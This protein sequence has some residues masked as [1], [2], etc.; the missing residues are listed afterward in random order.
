MLSKISPLLLTGTVAAMLLLESL[1]PLVVLLPGRAR[2]RH[3]ARNVAL[4]LVAAL[5][6]FSGNV[7]FIGASAWASTHHVGLLNQFDTPWALRFLVALLSI[8][9]FEYWRH[10]AHHR[11]PFLWRLH[12]VHHSDP[13]VDATTS[14]RGHPFES[15]IAYT[16]FTAIVLL[17]GLDPLSL[18]LR[19]IVAATALA[20]HHAGIRLPARADAVISLVTPTPRTH[21]VHHHRDVVFTDTNFGTLFTWWDRLFGTFTPGS[22]VQVDARTG[23]DGFDS[24]RAQSV[25]GV[26]LSPFRR[27]PPV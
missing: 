13:H 24:E 17:L 10:R 23:L 12:R 19:T 3:G 15:L 21:R 25:L 1:A 5:F 11:L 9:F 18:A 16:Y 6:A 8:D 7:V 27:A 22:R 20:W 4:A 26:L 14:V 2:L